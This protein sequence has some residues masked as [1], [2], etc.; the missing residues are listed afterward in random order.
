MQ[1]L[2]AFERV[3]LIESERFSEK[4]FESIKNKISRD[5][6]RQRMPF[7]KEEL[8]RMQTRVVKS[9]NQY[10]NEKLSRIVDCKNLV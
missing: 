1:I 6:A 3:V 10:L 5:C 2:P 8:L 4:L 9:A 7:D